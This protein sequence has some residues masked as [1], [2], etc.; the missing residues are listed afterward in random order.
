MKDPILVLDNIQKGYGET[1]VLRGIS[2]TIQQGS[3]TAFVGPNGA[4]KTTLFHT[5]TGDL[6]LDAGAV[7]FGG[8]CITGRAPWQ[9]A[10]LG[11]GKLFQDVRIFENLTVLE[12][13]LLA[14][15]DYPT[16]S[17]LK[18]ILRA[19]FSRRADQKQQAE[20]EKW[21]ETAGIERPYDQSAG[22]L[23]FGNKKLLAIARLM[24]GG[25]NLLLL[26]E[27]T[28]GLAPPMI[29]RVGELLKMLVRDHNVTVALIEHN[30][31]FVAQ[32]ADWTYLLQAGALV[33]SGPTGKVLASAENR[34]IL[35]GL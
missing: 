24:A 13:V 4:G 35:I 12:N 20:A 34:E 23:S 22:L 28:A 10:R 31:S 3:I 8:Q 14:V 2:A 18:S 19:P 26:D 17:V 7:F 29:Y 33:D 1:R 9:I 11:L 27:P 30:F 16:R 25:F 5:I 32:I 6:R 15:D 21:I